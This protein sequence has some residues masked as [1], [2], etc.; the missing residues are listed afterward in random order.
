MVT[1]ITF[2]YV[3]EVVYRKENVTEKAGS[4]FKGR[5]GNI[6]KNKLN[7]VFRFIFP[8]LVTLPNI[9]ISGQN[10]CQNIGQK[11]LT[12]EKEI[13]F[14]LRLLQSLVL[15]FFRLFFTLTRCVLL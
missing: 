2:C 15:I 12:T 10:E 6:N 7:I 1:I 13:V 3:L 5:M 14:K 9:K 11:F 8:P 4:A